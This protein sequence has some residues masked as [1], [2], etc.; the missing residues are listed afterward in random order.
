MVTRN[1]SSSSGP[2]D[3]SLDASSPYFVHS[4]DGPNSVSV[5]PLLTGSN[6]HSWAR[7]MRRALGGKMKFEFVDGTF[8]VVTDK[9]D[10]SYR[11]WNR[12]NMLVHSWILNSVSDSIAQS[13]MFMENAI[14]VWNDL[15]ER[16]SQGD[17][18]RV[19]ELMQE[20]YRLQQDSKS[21]TD[22]YSELKILWE[23]LEIYMHVP[24]CTCRSQ[25]SCEA[26]RKARQNHHTLYA[27][28]FLTGLNANFDMVRSQ[29]LLLDPL[30]PMNRVF[31]MV[32]QF[33]RQGNFAA[34][35]ESKVL[36]NY[37]DS[38]RPPNKNSKAS[39]SAPIKK[40]C[41][42]CD[43]PNHTVADCF[44]KHG[45]PPHMQ[46]NHGAYN[47]STEGGEASNTVEAPPAQPASSLSITQDQFDQLMQILQS[48]NINPSSGS[49]SSHQVNSSQS[50]GPSSNG[51]QGKGIIEDDWFS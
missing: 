49:T 43:K 4:S 9:F 23:E 22:F 51:R 14:D 50:F 39:S 32:L 47:A 29:I 34:I 12:C 6:Y 26:M 28:R 46:R 24:Q 48:S 11:A 21:V 18:V 15:K 45:Y 41:T 30:P 31:S 40:H 5:K 1:A 7:S 44:K 27:I 10:P 33:E 38:K 35:D 8:P 25:C 13:L 16:F 42:F 20:I 36:I 17:L 37:S 2:M 19:S 3:P